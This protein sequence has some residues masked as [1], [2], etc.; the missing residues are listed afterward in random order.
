[1]CDSGIAAITTSSSL[2]R[3]TSRVWA[4]LATRFRWVSSTLLGS[5]VV[6]LEVGR[7]ARPEA[8]AGTAGA[9]VVVLS[10]PKGIAPAAGPPIVNVA[11]IAVPG[12]TARS[13]WLISPAVA[14]SHRAPVGRS[15]REIS[16]AVHCGFTVVTTAPIEVAAYQATAKSRQFGVHK[17]STSPGRIPCADSPAPVPST[18]S[19]SSA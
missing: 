14:T 3:W 6:P 5:P 2:T 16:S 17:A 15:W 7:N 11:A 10:E 1:M 18:A 19:A 8:P 12:M 4:K 9:C 13:F